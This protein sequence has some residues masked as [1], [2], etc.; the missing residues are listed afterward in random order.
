MLLAGVGRNGSG[1]EGSWAGTVLVC[2]MNEVATVQEEVCTGRVLIWASI[3]KKKK[4]IDQG[5]C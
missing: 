1:R 3:Q 5:F 4:E 2:K